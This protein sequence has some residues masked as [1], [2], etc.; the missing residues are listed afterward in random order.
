MLVYVQYTEFCSEDR[1][2]REGGMGEQGGYG[3]PAWLELSIELPTHKKNPAS[4]AHPLPRQYTGCKVS[5]IYFCPDRRIHWPEAG[6]LIPASLLVTPSWQ[7]TCSA[8]SIS[9]S[10]C[11]GWALKGIAWDLAIGRPKIYGFFSWGTPRRVSVLVPGVTQR[12]FVWSI[13][14]IEML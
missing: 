3:Q 14:A 13:K 6:V 10:L 11:P 8:N 12:S 9:K 7:A 2:G 1:T 4:L 5:K